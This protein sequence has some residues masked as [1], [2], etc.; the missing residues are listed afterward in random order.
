VAAKH[1]GFEGLLA[2]QRAYL[3]HYW[4]RADVEI[5]GDPELDDVYPSAHVW[6]DLADG[7]TVDKYI[8]HPVGS[9]QNPL[10]DTQVEEKFTQLASA[11]LD[12]EAIRAAIDA[13]WSV[14]TSTDL[15]AFAT[16]FVGR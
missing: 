4:D 2:E 1:T 5:E 7:T 13:V 14:D 8:A 6:I 10:S 12:P 15:T 9:S 16:K 3:D 11:V